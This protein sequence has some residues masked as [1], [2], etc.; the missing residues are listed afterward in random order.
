MQ[1]FCSPTEEASEDKVMRSITRERGS[2]YPSREEF[3]KGLLFQLCISP[4][5]GERGSESGRCGK[6]SHLPSSHPSPG[7]SPGALALGTH[8]TA[9]RECRCQL[10]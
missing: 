2:R 5:C 3:E 4:G 10:F 6:G 8:D 9:L 7:V 1:T